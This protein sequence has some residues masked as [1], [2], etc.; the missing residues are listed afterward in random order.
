MERTW[1]VGFSQEHAGV[2]RAALTLGLELCDL[3]I[4]FVCEMFSARHGGNVEGESRMAE[5]FDRKPDDPA[6]PALREAFARLIQTGA[7]TPASAEDIADLATCHEK[8]DAAFRNNESRASVV[9][10]TS[11]LSGLRTACELYARLAI[12]QG[13]AV[14][15]Y[16]GCPED[17]AQAA[18]SFD[19]RFREI[20]FPELRGDAYYGINSQLVHDNARVAWDILQ[21][22]RQHLAFDALGKVVG[23]DKRDVRTMKGPDFDDPMQRSRL[24]LIRCVP[25]NR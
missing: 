4:D 17:A 20:L 14:A 6:C 19:Q 24:E 21:V 13:W 2:M 23:Q 5:R 12:S 7:P 22:V 25:G 9:L 15:G 3:K 10:S 8:V 11:E 1:L 18:H 16:L